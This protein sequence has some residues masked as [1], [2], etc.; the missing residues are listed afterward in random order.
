MYQNRLR[1]LVGYGRLMNSLAFNS[2]KM[3]NSRMKLAV[4]ANKKY[5]IFLVF[6]HLSS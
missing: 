1:M 2:G 6:L 5:K 4:K 3:S